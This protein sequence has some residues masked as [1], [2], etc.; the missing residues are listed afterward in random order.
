MMQVIERW[1]ERH[2]VSEWHLRAR[3]RRRSLCR[4]SRSRSGADRSTPSPKEAHFAKLADGAGEF[5]GVN[6]PWKMSDARR[7]VIQRKCC[8]LSAANRDDILSGMLGLSSDAN[9]R[10]RRGGCFRKDFRIKRD[11]RLGVLVAPQGSVD[12]LNL[13][14]MEKRP[15]GAPLRWPACI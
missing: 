4:I 1:T 3:P 9:Q 12:L 5:L 6:A 15:P 10:T 2:T 13:L 8:R 14:T 7:T 11:K